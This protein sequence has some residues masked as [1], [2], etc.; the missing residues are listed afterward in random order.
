ML[1]FEPIKLL[2]LYKTNIM[3]IDFYEVCRDR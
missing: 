1:M 3:Y 2:F